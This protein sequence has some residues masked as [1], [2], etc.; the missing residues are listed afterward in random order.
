MD[1]NTLVARAP[2]LLVQHHLVFSGYLGFDAQLEPSGKSQLQHR[3]LWKTWQVWPE[4]LLSLSEVNTKF[5]SPLN[6]RI[7]ILNAIIILVFG[8][9]EY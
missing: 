8:E 7:T 1:H 6:S 4:Q 2:S 5:P 3:S 9:T